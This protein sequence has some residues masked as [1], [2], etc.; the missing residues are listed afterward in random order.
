M[1][2]AVLDTPIAGLKVVQRHPRGDTRGF[3]ARLFDAADLAACGWTGPV[4]QVNHTY[5]AQAGTVR[6]MHY[7][8][9]PYAEMKLVSCIRG[10]VWDVAIDLRQGSPTIL[11]WHAERLSADNG[12]ALLI[13]EGFAHGF[14]TLTDD[15]EMLYC[16]SAS[17]APQAEAG[18]HYQEAR[19]GI[20]W[21]A[22][23]T[24]VS[25]RDQQHPRLDA[26]YSGVA[27]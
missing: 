20:S 5:T 23:P 17:Y 4:A 16:H 26:A 13:P 25:E 15:V 22:P 9:P 6:G 14:Q 11:Q 10:V 19:V 18:L 21:P 24:Q 3:L 7:Q 8:L 12:R 27:L 1:S 2:L